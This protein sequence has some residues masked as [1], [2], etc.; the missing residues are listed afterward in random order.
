MTVNDRK[1]RLYEWQSRNPIRIWRE[2]HAINR[3]E[4]AAMLGVSNGSLDN[5]ERGIGFPSPQNLILLSGVMG[6]SV[7]ILN[8]R[9]KEWQ[10]GRY[11]S[12]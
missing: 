8:Q 2:A 12:D 7:E 10:S 5:W 4:F 1:T 9:I 11:G 6:V 3:L